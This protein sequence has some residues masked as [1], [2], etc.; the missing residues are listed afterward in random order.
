MTRSPKA[1][2]QHS[3]NVERARH[4]LSVGAI[5]SDTVRSLFK[6]YSVYEGEFA[7]DRESVIRKKRNDRPGR[8]KVTAKRARR[9]TGKKGRAE[10]KVARRDA[11]LAAKRAAAKAAASEGA[12]S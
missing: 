6:R 11:R 7:R 4:W 9:L 3:L 5:P 8:K 1:E 12:A 2:A 10:A